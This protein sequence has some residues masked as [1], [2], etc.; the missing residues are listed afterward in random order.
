MLP[1]LTGRCPRHTLSVMMRPGAHCVQI[2]VHWKW[3]RLHI[4]GKTHGECGCPGDYKTCQGG[5]F[6]QGKARLSSLRGSV[7]VV[8]HDAMSI[9]WNGVRAS[10]GLTLG[11]FPLLRKKTARPRI[12]LPTPGLRQDPMVNFSLLV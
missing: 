5:S 12:G 1:I 2:T 8:V 7:V 6:S 10:T 11:G 9:S 4:A 3:V